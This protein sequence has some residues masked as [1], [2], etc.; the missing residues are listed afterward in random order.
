MIRSKTFTFDTF[1]FKVTVHMGEDVRTAVLKYKRSREE[2]DKSEL[3]DELAV[4]FIVDDPGGAFIFFN[5][6]RP[7]AAIIAHEAWHVVF[8]MFEYYGL[9]VKD[10]EAVAYHL[11]WLVHKI[12]K[13]LERK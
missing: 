6:S 3:G 9:D 2:C 12:H 8:G 13:M 4:T 5:D 1:G 11:M 7:N 10:E